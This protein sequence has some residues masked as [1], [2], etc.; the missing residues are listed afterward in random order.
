MGFENAANYLKLESF[1]FDIIRFEKT[2]N[3][4]ENYRC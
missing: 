3:K 4:V 1:L 2:L